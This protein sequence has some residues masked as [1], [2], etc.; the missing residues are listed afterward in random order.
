MSH[1]D[2]LIDRLL[3]EGARLW[4]DNGQVRF[5]APAGV[6]SEERIGQIRASKEAV[7]QSLTRRRAAPPGTAPNALTRRGAELAPL[8]SSQRRLWFAEQMG[9]A[10][11][12]YH[13]PAALSL[14]GELSVA[15]LQ[16]SLE[17]IVHR[18]ESLRTRFPILD[19]Q[20]YQ[21]IDPPAPFVL[22]RTDLS[23]VDDDEQRTRLAEF[24][25]RFAVES[26]DLEQGPLFRTNLVRLAP[27]RHVLLINLHHIVFDGW[28]LAVLVGEL[29]QAY[30]EHCN[31]S[32]R[33][34]PQPRA[35]YADYAF[36]EAEQLADE[37][38]AAPLQAWARCLDGAPPETTVPADWPRHRQVDYAGDEHSFQWPPSLS[39]KLKALVKE[40][41]C[42]VFAGLLASLNALLWRWA[43]LD[44]QV[45]G[46]PVACR[47]LP[48]TESMIGVLVNLLPLRTRVDGGATFRALVRQAGAAISAAHDLHDVPFE[49][50][51]E[52]TGSG[53]ERGLAPLFQM[54][55]A[56][57]NMP[58]SRPKLGELDVQLR[59]LPT[60]ASRFD[61]TFFVRDSDQGLGG[62]VEYATA[63][64]RSE[65]VVGVTR[66]LET[67]LQNLCD[68]PDAP[69]EAIPLM[70]AEERDGLLA[71]CRGPEVPVPADR[72]VI[73]WIEKQAHLGP[74]RPALC[75]DGVTLRRGELN[76]RAN[77][78]ARELRRRGVGPDVIVAVALERSFDQ[79]IALLAVLK[80]GGAYL[81]LEL[82]L[83][84]ERL[85]FMVEDS[86]P[87]VLLGREGVSGRLSL[88]GAAPAII[89]LPSQGWP[90]SQLAQDDLDSVGDSDCLA[91]VIYTSGS[92]GLPKGAANVRGALVNR[93][94]W[95]Q[96]AYPLDERDAVMQKTPCGFDVSVWEYFWPLMFGARLVIARP[97]GH[98]DPR[99]LAE[100]VEAQGVTTMHFVPSMLNLFL[101]EPEVSRCGSLK[102]V[103]CSGEA[104]SASL[105]DR[106]FGRL[107]AELHNL[108]GPTEAAIDVSHH[109]CQRD[110]GSVVPIGRP[111]DNVRLLVLDKRMN[112]VPAGVAGDL[113][114]GGIALA[115]GYVNR[116]ELT[117]ERFVPDPFAK[118]DGERLYRTGDRA[119]LRGDG[120][121][122][123]LGRDDQ[124]VKL[125]GQRLEL[126]EI[127]ARLLEDRRLR[128]AL[129]LLDQ[130]DGVDP[131]LVAYCVAE[132]AYAPTVD[133]FV[134]HPLDNGLAIAC[135]TAELASYLHR[136]IFVE[137][138][139]LR[140]GVQL[141]EDGC[142]FDVGANVGMFTLFVAHRAPRSRVFAF[143]P[144]EPI[145]CMLD[146]NVRLH[147][148]AAKVMPFGLS[149]HRA[150]VEFTYYPGAPLM[151]GLYADASQDA[152]VIARF[153]ENEALGKGWDGSPVARDSGFARLDAQ[154]LTCEVRTISE[155]IDENGIERID[156]L[157]IDVERAEWDVLMGIEPGHWGRIAQVVVEVHDVD[158]RLAHVLAL[159]RGNGFCCVT[160][161]HASLAGT[162]LHN[163]YAVRPGAVQR[164]AAPPARAAAPPADLVSASQL[165][166]ALQ[167]SLPEY[168]VPAHVVVLQALP[169]SPNGKVDR[170][171]LPVP[172]WRPEPA[173]AEPPRGRWEQALGQIWQEVLG[174]EEVSR[175]DRFFDIGGHSL[176]A[177]RLVS[178]VRAQL[179]VELTLAQVFDRPELAAQA[180][181]LAQSVRREEDMPIQATTR[182]GR[183]PL[184]FGQQRL[185]FLSQL[186]GASATY[187]VPM[188]LRLRGPLDRDA[189]RAA[190]EGLVARHEVLRSRFKS[191]EDGEPRLSL[192]ARHEPMALGLGLEDL[193]G[194]DEAMLQQ[195]Y[196]AEAARPFDLT[197]EAPLRA[198][199]VQLG[200]QEHVLLLTQHHIVS[201]GW[202]LQ[203]VL[204]ELAALYAGQPLPQLPVQ[205]VDYAA[206]QRQWLDGE[207]LRTQA[208]YWREAL[209]DAP[210]LLE[211]PTDR[212]RPA[213]QD[214]AGAVWPLELSPSLSQALRAWSR[215]QGVTLF[216]ALLGA[217]A[218]VLARLSGQREV[219]IGT[220]S[221]NRERAELE[222]L[223]GFFVNTLVMRV[224]VEGGRQTGQ[225]MRQVRERVL[226][227]QQN[228]D[229]PFE[230]VVE[231]VQPPRQMAYSPVFQ[232][233][234]LWQERMT[235]AM[236]L[237]GL[238]VELLQ[239]PVETAKFDLTLELRELGDRIAG[240]LNYATALF[241]AATMARHAGYLEA[242]LQELVAGEQRPVDRLRMLPHAERHQLLHTW[243][244]TAVPLPA[245]V[246]LH[247]LVRAQSR[248][249]PQAVA[250]RCGD[251]VLSYEA[252]DARAGALA[253]V[254]RARG[255]GPESRVAI[256]ATR[257][258]YLITGVLAVLRAGGA[259]VSL[260]P[261]YPP[262]R[263]AY[264]LQDTQPV[265]L[266]ADEVGLAA[267][268]ST[269]P[270][271][272]QR[273]DEPLHGDDR[274]ELDEDAAVD[275][276]RAA[277]LIYTSG[278]TGHPKGV[279]IEHGNAVNLVCWAMRSFGPQELAHT[280]LATSLNFDLSIYECFVPLAM[281]ATV[282]LVSDA[283]ALAREPMEAALTLVNG[284]PSAAASLLDARA[285]PASV[286]TLNLAGEPLKAALVQRLFAETALQSVCNLYGPSETTTYSTWMRMARGQAVQEHIG[287]PIDN[288][289]LYVLD[290]HGEP[291][292]IGVVGELYIGG[293]G[294]A[295]GY[296]NR[297]QLTAERFLDDPY[298]GVPGAR[299]YR[300]GDLARYRADG[301]VEFLGRNDFQ[302]KLRG[303]RIELGEIE[304]GLLR[305][306]GV[307]E[308]VAMRR[309]DTPGAPCLV[310]YVTFRADVPAASREPEAA[311]AA[312]RAALQRSLPEYMV[313]AHVVVL[314]ALPLSPNGKVDRRALPVPDVGIDLDTYVA[315]RTPTETTLAELAARALA[316]PRVGVH[317]DFFMLG[318]HSL[319]AMQVNA[320]I[321]QD[322]GVN[323][324]LRTL[325]ESP[326]VAALAEAVDLERQRLDNL[327]QGERRRIAEMLARLSPEEKRELL[328]RQLDQRPLTEEVRP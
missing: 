9:N 45:I 106:F 205:Y 132:S 72:N 212:P 279:V 76:H 43:G 207:R 15:A 267:L 200:E 255:V 201:D 250:L 211:L 190:L 46:T 322:L 36:W 304:S 280:L 300:T 194:Q 315:P 219:L 313:P 94:L 19:G 222:S 78:L 263:L 113:Y 289:R 11:A 220:P 73:A 38:M 274:V 278:S 17:S 154:R 246:G 162:D 228:Q 123:Y 93:L 163:V 288:T 224:E 225:F 168:M 217:W 74:D 262:D 152:S 254:L 276:H 287:R 86:R 320:R 174:R 238:S 115:R 133:G 223:V 68:A 191:G 128:E 240:G 4:A 326:T 218:I 146:V 101:D 29:A 169:L 173:G 142:V 206:W 275:A 167:R 114:I 268:P 58:R 55:L 24:E 87:R 295:R 236:R 110:E 210:L 269:G 180:A 140:H 35:Q 137:E 33:S 184:S 125:R 235:E 84:D 186:E 230:Q 144:V 203:V 312:L 90:F 199:L 192:V 75:L 92:T 204:R 105:R 166:A 40:E 252:L 172:Q 41:G 49:R 31:G 311:A 82:D 118:R 37:R 44:D 158:D 62:Y 18:H 302:V 182:E 156:L 256:C 245:G 209:A 22:A 12:T 264:L 261:S 6:L 277:Y 178:R 213:R 1:A 247:Q 130:R 170:R 88:A 310:A 165:R 273:L 16:S 143:E 284:V 325:F 316:R 244:D 188:A 257:R 189:L 53:R 65:T 47:D 119:R 314:Q 271:A 216:M 59:R 77:Q 54:A 3:L 307:H 197:H 51:V 299:M 323:L 2:E 298:A 185:W 177:V 297:P 317:D 253:R 141:P 107:H 98:R 91:Y 109:A 291:V 126:G 148:E 48:Q 193:R 181:L 112:V 231:I 258:P 239:P 26:F 23:S 116:A 249:T 120:N 175:Q 318:G 89:T 242:V 13:V 153:V 208:A 319:M 103:I 30:E 248:R 327:S 198:R 64:Y 151:S 8:S 10:G 183:L 32:R 104:L 131:S 241:D 150:N 50:L 176:L 233:M 79:V 34:S 135:Q 66:T 21:R 285:L 100:L 136:E 251:E 324:P 139:Y 303:Y 296:L 171:A 28:S 237:P 270:L 229:L 96:S 221:A 179:G 145:R 283:L 266:M 27:Q 282:H 81:P 234:F 202:S 159:L 290:P 321:R 187:N 232:V 227:A 42:T 67:L 83:P 122:E 160:E 138:S 281:G 56:F 63:L 294:V 195:V 85:S 7:L 108:Y 5:R 102:R 306:P 308:A 97:G 286:R 243:N 292:A 39:A 328:R 215:M 127:E 71:L 121:L 293:A 111:I 69:I 52:L 80:A 147:A 124:Q 70:S 20:P 129:V 196:A 149:S 164:A 61:L 309:E 60:Q 155:V 57:E 161:Q 99:Y 14:N 272:V 95:M 265:L 157:K 259:F 260:D 214:H 117:R 305:Q 226:Q 134:R 25:R 301:N